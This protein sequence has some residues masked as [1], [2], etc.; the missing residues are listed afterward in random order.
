MV[1]H[2]GVLWR[3]YEAGLL[4]DLARISSVSGG[5]ITYSQFK[6]INKIY[7]CHKGFLGNNPGGGTRRKIA[8]LLSWSKF[9]RSIGPVGKIE[10]IFIKQYHIYSSRIW[11]SEFDGRCVIKR[12]WMILFQPKK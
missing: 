6:F 11:Y 1:F 9:G 12:I 7:V 3:L 8:P 10:Y 2:I 5:S 4:R